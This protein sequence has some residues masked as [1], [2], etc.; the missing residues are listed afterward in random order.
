M[1]ATMAN[2]TMIKFGH[3]DTL[4]GEYPCWVVLIRPQQV[5]LGALVLACRE[6]ATAFSK[7]SPQAF[8]ELGRVIPEMEGALARAFAYD[9]INYL[10]LM[11]VDPNVHFHVIPRYAEPRRFAGLSFADPGWP[12]QPDMAGAPELDP[13]ML[14][15]IRDAVKQQWAPAAA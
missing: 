2:Q 14:G 4:V 8:A 3:P 15:R 12:K 1:S 13:A 6:P 5:T 11:M 10:M 9:K 7:I